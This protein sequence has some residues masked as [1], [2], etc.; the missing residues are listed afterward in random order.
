MMLNVSNYAFFLL[1]VNTLLSV[2]LD[3]FSHLVPKSA[4]RGGCSLVQFT[5]HGLLLV[6]RVTPYKIDENKS[7]N[8][9]IDK[10]QNLRKERTKICNGSSQDSYHRNFSY[11]RYSE[12]YFTQ[13]F[14]GL[15]GDAML[16]PHPDG[17]Q[18][19]DQ[20]LTEASVTGFCSKSVNL[21]LEELKNIKIILFI[22][23]E[24]FR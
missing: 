17:H 1:C 9:L 8:R 19:G 13:L 14:G 20:K 23:Q 7:Q 10:V 18:H 21:S 16:V 22:T 3:L 4:S 15:Y 12:K 6:F 5:E 24:R 11:A 2:V